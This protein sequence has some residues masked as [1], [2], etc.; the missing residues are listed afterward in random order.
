MATKL[1]VFVSSTMKDLANE[2]HAVTHEIERFNFEPV[3]TEAWSPD[4]SKSWETIEK[5]LLSSHLVVL[6]LGERYGHIPGASPWS[7]P[8]LGRCLLTQAPGSEPDH[9]T[10]KEQRTPR[11]SS[12]AEKS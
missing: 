6:L 1:R 12:V 4:G 11:G 8:S 10:V 5:E 7:A 2:R 9:E 3:N